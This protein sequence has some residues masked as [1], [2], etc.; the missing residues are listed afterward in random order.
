MYYNRDLS[1][2]GFNKRVLLEANDERVPLFE[3][4]RFLSIFSSNLDEFFRVRY[5]AVVALSTLKPKIRHKVIDGQETDD[6]ATK[7]QEE[8]NSQL[9][10]YGNILTQTLL[11]ALDNNDIHLYYNESILPE[12]KYEV[13]EL[14][15]SKP[16]AFVQPQFLKHDS[17]HSFIPENNK[18]YLVITL[19][20]AESD[21]LQQ[22]VIEI[23]SLYLPRFYS[24]SKVGE[25]E[26]IIF[27]DDVIRENVH[28]I[29][30]GFEILGV[31]SFK[32]NRDA[33]LHLEESY[34]DDVLHRIERQL[35]KRDFGPPSRFLHQ[36]E[37]PRNLRMFL[38]SSFGAD[39]D[40]M[41]EG[42]RYHILK[43]FASLPLGGKGLEYES[44][45]PLSALGL[46]QCSNIFGIIESRD[47]LLHFPYNSYNPILAFFNQAAIDPF[48]TKIYITLYRVASDSL[49]V[50]ALISAARNGKVVTVFVELKARFDESNNIHWSRRMEEAGVNIVYSIPDIKVHA[51]TALIIRKKA[52]G[53][54][55]SLGLISTGNFNESTARFYT[56]HT[57]LTASPQITAEMLELFRFLRRKRRDGVAVMPAFQHLLVA[58]AN[59]IDVFDKLVCAEK[60]KVR[61]G[62]E[63]DIS[64][65]LNNLEEPQMIASLQKAAE[66]GVKIRLLVRG[67]CC[68]VPNSP[69]IEVRR[70]VDRYLEHTRIFM[71]GNGEEIK[72]YM[73]S[74]DWMTRNLHHRVEVITPVL[75][76]HCRQELT[77]YFNIQWR[78]T[79][80]TVRLLPDG[81]Q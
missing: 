2:L 66:V 19:K 76:I 1:W 80:K 59:M 14:F 64:I 68:L 31:Y 42:G 67:I 56:D 6:L 5:P 33:E 15:L 47:V 53:E 26:Y 81:V 7:V 35:K 65:K 43:D 52:D 40:E 72:V 16:L 10:L 48:V 11:P 8:V 39:Q 32:F 74:A 25:K 73:G 71:F 50:N 18:L 78:N 27:L 4:F 45:R 17:K 38:A 29:F 46:Q 9:E 58:G 28:C 54:S 23:P 13:E 30:P 41:F 77:D 69:N 75:E 37:M 49:I 62:G 24:L 36:P 55:T 44:R 22:A 63:G 70:I 60:D 57:L 34:A 21:E 51:K 20:H 79:G 61:A 12:H 3:R